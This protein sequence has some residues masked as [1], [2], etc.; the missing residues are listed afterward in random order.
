MSISTSGRPPRAPI[1]TRELVG[2]DDRVR[3]GGRA[4]RR[5]RRASSSRGQV[6][7][8]RDAAA[9]ALGQRQRAVAAAV[10]DEHGRGAPGGQRL[11]RQ[12]AHLAG[13]EDHHAALAQVADGLAR[14]RRR[15]PRAR[16]PRPRPIAVSRAH[17][18]AGGQRG[19]E[20]AVGQRAG[21]PG[22]ERELVGAP[23]LALDLGLADDHRL[24]ARGRRGRGGARRRSC[25]ASR[26][27]R[28]ARSGG[29]RP[30]GRASPSTASRP[31]T[32]SPT[33]R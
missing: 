7:E 17:A 14:Q 18:L 2:A 33:T 24:Q 29:C 15:R 5:C 20:Q 1:T 12:L 11:G 10:G 19:A 30:G 6:V 13:A 32:G 9:E 26:S 22:R 28:P 25:A 21:R 4:R 8:R 16:W 31:A 3:R 23:D 27:P